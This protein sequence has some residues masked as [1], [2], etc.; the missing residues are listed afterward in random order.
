[1]RY[2]SLIGAGI[3]EESHSRNISIKMYSI[4]SLC[5]FLLGN[6][7]FSLFNNIHNTF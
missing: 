4:M 7:P 3:G 1:M 6:V 5:S 2:I